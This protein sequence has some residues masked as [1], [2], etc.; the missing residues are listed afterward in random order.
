MSA[1]RPQMDAPTLLRHVRHMLIQVN[2]KMLHS[3]NRK[4][5]PTH[6]IA[7][8]S[9]AA[10]RDLR[11]FERRILDSRALHRVAAAYASRNT[12]S[13]DFDLYSLVGLLRYLSYP[14]Q[15]TTLRALAEESKKLR[16][17]V[18]TAVRVLRKFADLGTVNTKR[19]WVL[20]VAEDIESFFMFSVASHASF[21]P[22][23]QLVGQKG[24]RRAFVTRAIAANVPDDTESRF[25]T[26]AELVELTGH[27]T[28]PQLV[29]STLLKGAT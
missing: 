22:Y 28:S 14:L 25:T 21:L 13:R 3:Q 26:I 16:E 8:A 5:G 27:D 17:D 19:E 10:R 12:G 4:D 2:R 7:L 24:D 20:E 6:K 18:E 9:Y 23:D 29:R 15:G 11:K 1:D